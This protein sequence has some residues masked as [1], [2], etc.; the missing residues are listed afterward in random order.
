MVKVSQIE[1]IAAIEQR[2]RNQVAEV[3][4][5]LRVDS[6][7]R[8]PNLLKLIKEENEKFRALISSLQE[9]VDEEKTDSLS[10]LQTM[11]DLAFETNEQV[12]SYSMSDSKA[13]GIAANTLFQ[14][15]SGEYTTTAL[16]VTADLTQQLN[17][18]MQAAVVEAE[19]A[20]EETIRNLTMIVAVVFVLSGLSALLVMRQI[21]QGFKRSIALARNV[22]EGDLRNTAEISGNNEITDLLKAQND[23]VVH[24]RETVG[25]VASAVRNLAA[26][27]TQMAG[28]SESLSEGASVQAGS[29]EEVSTAVEQMSANISASS[30][31]AAATEEIASKAAQDAQVS[32][33]TVSEAVEAMKTIGERIMILQEIARQTDLLALNAA[34][35]A[36]RAGE[37][38]RGF[39]VV[40]A[41]VR[42]LA[43][44]SQQAAAEISA[45]SSNTVSTAT[46]AGEMLQ[47]LVPNI[48]KT[49]SLVSDI[50]SATRELAIGSTQINESVQRLDRVTQSNNSAAEELSSAAT[51]LSSQA[52][53]LAEVI[54]FFRIDE[55]SAAPEAVAEDGAEK[56]TG[57]E[58]N[59][60]DEDG[61]SE[62]ADFKLAS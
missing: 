16:E 18:A 17:E 58:L 46:K 43:E 40:A 11:H 50:S 39:A 59:L 22:A 26:G 56:E 27:A 6:D 3:L 4:I 42:K 62:E 53:Q 32:G 44:N 41:E 13:K 23:M 19:T 47:G 9:K 34:V 20:L 35:E 24:L 57:A 52:E 29:T 45:L 31:N 10:K 15:Q 5:P 38:G 55:G 61:A 60:G 21:S 12:V 2:M 25:N 48:E 51:E 49:S 28:T 14:N 33:S 37:H 8:I 1:E 7:E 54:S 30:D 36:A